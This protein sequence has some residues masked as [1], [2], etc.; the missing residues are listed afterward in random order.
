ME[1]G[2]LGI[3]FFFVSYCIM[4]DG[5]CYCQ[6]FEVVTE[7]SFGDVKLCSLVDVF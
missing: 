4:R 6:I 2:T 5:F 1:L 3:F 7:I